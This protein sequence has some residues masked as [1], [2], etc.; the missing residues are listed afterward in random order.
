MG[1]PPAL[2]LADGRLRVARL[3]GE[4]GMGVVYEAFDRELRGPVAVKML[5]NVN[6]EAMLRL[7]TEFRAL[8]D[9]HHPNLVRLGEL[10]ADQRACFFTMELVAGVDLLEYVWSDKPRRPR[11]K[12][13]TTISGTRPMDLSQVTVAD[14]EG[15]DADT[16]K[17]EVLFDE[18]RLRETLRQVAE[19]LT[20]LHDHGKVHRDIKPTNILVEPGGRVVL[21]DLGLAAERGEKTPQGWIEGTIEYMAPEQASGADAQ[22]PV[23]LYGL[24]TILYEALVG[25]PPFI[26]DAVEV[27]VSKQQND[28]LSPGALYPGVP[29]DLDELCMSLLRRDPAQRPTARDLAEGLATKTGWRRK[30]S[31]TEPPPNRQPFVG[32]ATELDELRR[33]FHDSRDKPIAMLVVGESGTGKTALARRF[34][35]ETRD[36]GGLLFAGRCHA[37]ESVPFRAFDGI[38][39][40]ISRFLVGTP[41]DDRALLLPRDV[42]GLSRLFR[43]FERLAPA[44]PSTGTG[45]DVRA[46]RRRAFAALHELLSNLARHRPLALVIDDLQWI[47]ADTLL[48]F[49]GVLGNAP[50]PLLLL[51]LMRPA[52]EEHDTVRDALTALG[53]EVRELALG[54]LGD[55]DS[56]ALARHLLPRSDDA[57]LSRVAGASHGSPLFLEQMASAVERGQ[58]FGET[59]QQ[60]V[61]TRISE[62]HDGVPEVLDL[63]C[64]AGVALD[65]ASIAR[66]SAMQ[67]SQFAG[68]VAQLES[69]RLVR[70]TGVRRQDL[71]EPYHDQIRQA[72]LTRLTPEQVRRRHH[73]L[74]DVLERRRAPAWL[75][76][77]HWLAAG[78]P[79]RAAPHAVEA[80]MGAQAELSARRVARLCKIA[81]GLLPVSHEAYP[82][83]CRALAVSL[84]NA[85]QGVEAATWY[86]TAAGDGTDL[87][88]LELR[89]QAGEHL[90]RAGRVEEGMQVLRDVL[91]AVDVHVPTTPRRALAAYL[92]RRAKLRLRGLEPAA[93]PAVVD[94]RARIRADVCLS[95]GVA[96]GIIDFITGAGLHSL[97]LLEAL[98]LAEPERIAIALA[99][100]GGYH[101]AD[102]P[103]GMAKTQELLRRA[104]VLAGESQSQLAAGMVTY[105]RCISAFL[106]GRFRDA[107]TLGDAA[108]RHFAE[109]CPGHVWE[110]AS[111]EVFAAWATGHCGELPELEGRIGDIER[112]ARWHDDRYTRALTQLGSGC[113]LAIADDRPDEATARI[114]EAMA[115]WPASGFHLTH[116]MELQ[117]RNEVDLYCGRPSV[118]WDR[119]QTR[120]PELQRS[121][122]L[123]IQHS[124]LFMLDGR[125][126]AAL[127]VGGRDPLGEAEDCAK[128][129]LR[130][131][132]PWALG[133][134]RARL[135]A[136]AGARGQAEQAI[137]LLKQAIEELEV[138]G[139]GLHAAANRLRLAALEHTALERT[140]A[141]GDLVRRGVVSPEKWMGNF[142]PW[143]NIQR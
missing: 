30:A 29:P 52:K 109:H 45:L 123:R 133:L 107:T 100:E 105:M 83:L 88:A 61:W 7:K 69:M 53:V 103:A 97:G 90:L 26:G 19:G 117:N 63:V 34:A 49:E 131:N 99:T 5:R 139:L 141:W 95:T 94:E 67:R 51:G 134:G 74:A 20:V 14:D 96:L 138:A 116:L 37:Q 122:L 120:W 56:L 136:V 4:G 31:R 36:K 137:R 22:P 70:T 84:A 80:A 18:A 32:R 115:M 142:A 40:A 15:W 59:L 128:T 112:V 6:G 73:V 85:G 28:P 106:E 44:T 9:L 72:V 91:A 50:P 65:Q 101:A 27:L 57:T 104:E 114:D 66:A 132:A 24:G 21:L 47:D 10:F 39:D 129:I 38:A 102:G 78:E 140:P 130:E 143:R 82:V 71:I 127:S 11:R 42:R 46:R 43:V 119:M 23:D 87:D 25:R 124:R 77:H 60:V 68:A 1:E 113:L 55:S 118:A 126:R 110:Q 79:V 111:A 135:A 98:R 125:A 33:A 41:P 8:R 54:P 12:A 75:V 3:L 121:L 35:L 17:L 16:T 64:C 86:L 13:N 93:K 48:L 92:W 58:D 108:S 81:I 76:F 89:R 2:V 62:L